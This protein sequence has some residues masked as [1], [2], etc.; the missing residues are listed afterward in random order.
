MG[1]HRRG[2][3]WVAAMIRMY[4]YSVKS[5][6]EGDERAGLGGRTRH[7]V[8]NEVN[9]RSTKFVPSFLYEVSDISHSKVR[10][11]NPE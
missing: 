8:P 5:Y 6:I 3:V 11:L 9:V 10:A 2:G 4:L 1:S 7:E